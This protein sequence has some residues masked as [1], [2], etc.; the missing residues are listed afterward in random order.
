MVGDRATLAHLAR[1]AERVVATSTRT[2]E[3]LDQLIE[4]M[5]H[6]AGHDIGRIELRIPPD[7]HDIAASLRRIGQV[8]EEHYDERDAALIVTALVPRRYYARFSPFMTS[9]SA[10]NHVT[11]EKKF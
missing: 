6:L 9:G 7:R 2:R 11:S 8:E 1:G 4:A 10:S 3:G 5:A